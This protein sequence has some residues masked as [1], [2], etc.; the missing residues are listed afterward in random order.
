MTK[1]IIRNEHDLI[2]V[3]ERKEVTNAFAHELVTKVLKII[4]IFHFETKEELIQVTKDYIERW[5]YNDDA[6]RPIF[7][8]QKEEEFNIKEV[9]K[10]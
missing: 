6:E 7:L 8:Q 2:E 4:V 3:I 9:F 10:C 5:C 1:V